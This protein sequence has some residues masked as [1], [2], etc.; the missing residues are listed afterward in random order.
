MFIVLIETSGNQRYIFATNA[1][2]C[3][4]TGGVCNLDNW[5]SGLNSR[6]DQLLGGKVQCNESLNNHR[7]G[8]NLRNRKR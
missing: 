5:T 8:M 6:Y 7:S 1:R 2:E 3:G 4:D